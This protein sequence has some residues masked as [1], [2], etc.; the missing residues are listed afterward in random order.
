MANM[1]APARD[2]EEG[3]EFDLG[4][5][6]FR[7]IAE[8]VGKKTGIQ[9]NDSKRELVY[10]RLARRLRQLGMVTFAEYCDL[11]R[12]DEG[13]EMLNLVNAI[14][15]NL[16]SFFRERHHFDYLGTRLVP[17][18]LKANAATRRIRIWSAG[19]ST[20]A[21]PY[22][23]AITLREALANARGWEASIL[24]SDIDTN[25]LQ[26]AADGV[27]AEKEVE[28]LPPA[29]LRRWFLRGKG[30]NSGRVRAK[31]ELRDMIDFRQVNLIESSWPV[32]GPF[33]AIFCRNVV[34]YFDKPT[35]KMLFERYADLLVPQG[36]L[37]IG[38]SESLFKVTDRFALLGQTIYR[39]SA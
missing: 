4:D 24:A 33:D 21:E 13:E 14:T 6:E 17:E 11:L 29:Q 18:L 27:Y 12:R 23:I 9:L 1:T 10:G 19:C 2:K 34:I 39:R 3:R 25:V 36:R 35:Q 20:G 15:T 5:K 8:L 30:A 32:Q 28:G 26:T 37:F 7:F 22:S 38:H 16:T 31:D